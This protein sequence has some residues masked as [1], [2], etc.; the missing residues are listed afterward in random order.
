[1]KNQ[2]KSKQP[3][4]NNQL[5]YKIRD[6][7]TGLYQMSGS[8]WSKIGK[9]WTS[10]GHLKNHLRCIGF[11]DITKIPPNLEIVILMEIPNTLIPLSNVLTIKEQ[12]LITLALKTTQWNVK[13][14]QE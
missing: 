12:D 1:M 5:S 8:T 6:R 7:S 3:K 9:T 13:V 14:D 11:T 2:K 10:L 4:I